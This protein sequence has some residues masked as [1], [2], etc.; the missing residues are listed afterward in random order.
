MFIFCVRIVAPFELGYA[1]SSKLDN[2]IFQKEKK[3]FVCLKVSKGL[4]KSI[5]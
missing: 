2:I 5:L 1:I 4:A 3:L